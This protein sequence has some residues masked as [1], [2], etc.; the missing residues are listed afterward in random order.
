MK[1][2]SMA[3]QI[4]GGRALVRFRAG[5]FPGKKG[6]PFR[7]SELRSSLHSVMYAANLHIQPRHI[8]LTSS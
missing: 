7:S 1:V 8:L 2:H 5:F 6:R 3:K 4:I